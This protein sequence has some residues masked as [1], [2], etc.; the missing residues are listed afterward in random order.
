M[1]NQLNLLKNFLKT[2][3][4]WFTINVYNEITL[5]KNIPKCSDI[6]ISTM[7]KIAYLNKHIDLIEIFWK[8]PVI[9]YHIRSCGVIK[10]QM[11]ISSTSE[12][13]IKQRTL[14]RNKYS[15]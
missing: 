6:Y 9:P 10:K 14:T 15:N 5:K 11:K 13:E 3:T 2:L 1:K 12:E 7:T 4:Q 8:I